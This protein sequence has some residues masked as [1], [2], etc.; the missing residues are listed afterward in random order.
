M[1]A[2]CRNTKAQDPRGV[3]GLAKFLDDVQELIQEVGKYKCPREDRWFVE[4]ADG[5]AIGFRRQQEAADCFRT[6]QVDGGLPRLYAA[7]L[8]NEVTERATHCPLCRHKLPPKFTDN[9]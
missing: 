4:N 7:E 8:R 3:L 2:Y 5:G 6:M 1:A 9:P